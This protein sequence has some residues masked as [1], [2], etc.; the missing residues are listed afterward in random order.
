M[1]FLADELAGIGIDINHCHVTYAVKCAGR[2]PK[3]VE[4]TCAEHLQRE[5]AIVKPR[6]IITLGA[7]AFAAI[8]GRSPTWK[9]SRGRMISHGD[10]II[11]PTVSPATVIRKPSEK[12]EWQ[13]DL[14][15]F[16]R[17]IDCGGVFETP[18]D[19]R[20]VLVRHN[21]DLEHLVYALDS[22]SNK[23]VAYDIETTSIK[24]HRT[25]KILMFGLTVN[26]LCWVLPWEQN[27]YNVDKD[28]IVE[29]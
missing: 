1:E 9:D 27:F 12:W 10:S 13:A 3:S 18:S 4:K 22:L 16:K 25:G 26:E 28:R 17:V 20:W 14:E 24:D 23:D 19:F 21:C 8:V 6:Y 2:H 29:I 7:S 11:L 15:Y 5:I